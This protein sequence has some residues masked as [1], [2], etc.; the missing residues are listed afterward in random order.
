MFKQRTIHFNL[1]F[2]YSLLILCIIIGFISAFYFYTAQALE[3]KAS[4]SLFQLSTYIASQIDTNLK[5]MNTISQKMLFSEPLM[6]LIYSNI[7]DV[8]NIYEQRK[9]N[10]LIYSITG[11]QF[12]VF[13]INT[14]QHNGNFA[15]VGHKN[16]FSTLSTTGFN[17]VYWFVP[18][19]Q[20]QKKNTS[21]QLLFL[22]PMVNWFIL[23]IMLK[24]A[25]QSKK[26]IGMR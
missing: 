23:S 10:Q 11:P 26:L 5:E 19:L 1:F 9:F 8:N 6:E 22:I 3:K 20:I 21:R 18:V 14:I 17:Q 13:Q 12:P 4:E 15:G 2:S 16:S 7:Y 25:A 24:L